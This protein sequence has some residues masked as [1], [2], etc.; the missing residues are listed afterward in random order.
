MN[1][2]SRSARANPELAW[3]PCVLFGTSDA[4]KFLKQAP[5]SGRGYT[6]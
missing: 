5:F 2:L 1:Q 3:F 6:M 4:L